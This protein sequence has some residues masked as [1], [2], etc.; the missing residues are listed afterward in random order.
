M[1][2]AADAFFVAHGLRH[3]LAQ[4]DANVFHRVV[5]VNVQIAFAGNLQ[6]DQAVAS[7]LV[8]HVVEK[9]DAGGELGLTRTVQIQTHTNLGFGGLASDFSLTHEACFEVGFRGEHDTI[10]PLQAR[11]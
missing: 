11:L 9:T 4:G 7:D 10:A 8:Q 3:R 6:I 1:T 5:A 2:V